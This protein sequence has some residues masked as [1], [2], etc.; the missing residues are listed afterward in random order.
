MNLKESYFDTGEIRL[1]VVE[2]PQAGPPLVLLHGATGNAQAWGE[3]I[4][5]LSDQWHIYALDLRGHGLSERAKNL[6]GYHILCFVQ[7]VVTFLRER[8]KQPAVLMGHSYGAITSLLAGMP[9][10]DSLRALVLEDPPLGLRRPEEHLEN[11]YAN[12]FS[13]VYQ[14][15]QSAHTVEEVLAAL[16]KQTPEAPLETL[17]PWAQSLAW[18]DPLFVLSLITGDRRVP[19]QGVDFQTHANGIACPVLIMQADPEKGAALAQE[20]A[21]FFLANCPQAKLVKFPGAGHGIHTEQPEQFLNAF[22]EFFA[23]LQE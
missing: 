5:R 18:V 17:R 11:P 3:I 10:K 2:S 9:A 7:D 16:A 4:E 14:M 21:D 13:M 15:R 6:E 23:S 22:N 20:D 19:M 8:V 12:Y 1:H